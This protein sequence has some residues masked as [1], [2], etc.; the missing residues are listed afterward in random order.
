MAPCWLNPL[1]RFY[2]IPAAHATSTARLRPRHIA[3]GSPMDKAGAYGIQE[4][5]GA[6]FV[7]KIEGDYYNVVG[8]PLASIAMSAPRPPVS[9]RTRPASPGT[10]AASAP[11]RSANERRNADGSTAMTRTPERRAGA[12]RA[13]IQNHPNEQQREPNANESPTP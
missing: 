11:Q 12:N 1:S 5:H 6:V 2:R 8:L 10:I 4:D 9:E 3:T 13:Q 7:K